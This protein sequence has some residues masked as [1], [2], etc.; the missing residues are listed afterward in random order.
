M[1]FIHAPL[2]ARYLE[3]AQETDE[4]WLR[5]QYKHPLSDE[6]MDAISPLPFFPAYEY[7]HKPKAILINDI[8]VPEPVREQL[9]YD[10]EFWVADVS[11]GKP[12]RNWW[13]GSEHAL[14]WLTAGLIHM[15]EEAAQI[16]IDAMLSFTRRGE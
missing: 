7:R 9:M 2:I 8:E 12:H 16:H 1:A 13:T 15:T 6:W 14:H 10:Q 4:P 11:K 3:D 5:W